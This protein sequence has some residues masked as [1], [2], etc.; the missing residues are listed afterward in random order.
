MTNSYLSIAFQ[1]SDLFII[2]DVPNNLTR[3]ITEFVNAARV[4]W[5]GCDGN[6]TLREAARVDSWAADEG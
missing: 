4:G 2:A 5:W 3:S 6:P 1:S